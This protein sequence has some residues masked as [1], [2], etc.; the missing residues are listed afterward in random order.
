MAKS[1]TTYTAAEWAQ[2][3][4]HLRAI[5]P[6]PLNKLYGAKGPTAQQAED[7]AQRMRDWNRAY[8]NASKMQKMKLAEE[9]AAFRASRKNPAPR[10]KAADVKRFAAMYGIKISPDTKNGILV[11]KDSW[12]DVF[13][14]WQ[15]LGDFF[16]KQ[17]RAVENG[18]SPA[19]AKPRKNPAPRA[20]VEGARRL[21]AR[22]HGRQP[23]ESEIVAYP[24][25]KLPGAMANIGEI[26]AIEYLAERDGK[27]YRF[28]HVFKVKSRPQLAV[29]PDGKFVTMIGGSWEF[30]EDGFEDR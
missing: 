23:D 14:N 28:R 30:T 25:P 21:A 26:F 8:R 1:D 11:S 18:D 9:N 7:H 2:E 10:H 5:K 6:R 15:E 29:S 19:W 22:F 12:L 13:E 3:M 16:V 20:D 4:T 24:A 27:A 17:R